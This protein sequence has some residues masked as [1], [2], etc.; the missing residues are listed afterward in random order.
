[1]IVIKAVH[2]IAPGHLEFLLLERCREGVKYYKIGEGKRN[3]SRM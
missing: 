3:G 1:M 2:K